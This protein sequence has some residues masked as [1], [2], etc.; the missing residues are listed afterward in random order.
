[1]KSFRNKLIRLA[2]GTPLRAAVTPY[3]ITSAATI[4][5]ARILP[6][7][8]LGN[9]G[10]IVAFGVLII[11]AWYQGIGPSVISPLLL[12]LSFRFRG[13]GLRDLF[14]F[15][16]KDCLDIF[17]ITLVITSVGVAGVL[18]RRAQAIADLR[19]EQ[20]KEQDRH[21]DEFLATLAHE[22]R[23]PLAPIRMGLEVMEMLNIECSDPAAFDDVKR[24]MRRQVDHMVRLIDDLLDVSR[25]KTGKLVI[26]PEPIEIAL[27]INDALE[28]ARAD[29][30]AACHDL[31]VDLPAEPILMN[32]DRVRMTQVIVNLLNNATKFT[33]AG[34]Q[35]HLRAHRLNDTLEIR[36]RDTGIG[37]SRELLP[38]VF[39]LFVQ[40]EDLLTRTHGGLGIGLSLVHR[41]M[42]LHGGQ[43]QAHSDGPGLGSEFVLTLPCPIQ[44]T[45]TVASTTRPGE[46]LS[47]RRILVVDDNQDAAKT[48]AMMLSAQG[49]HCDIAFDGIAA[50]NAAQTLRPDVFFLDL[51]MPAMSGFELANKLRST[52]DF[53]SSLLIAVT[54]WGRQQDRVNCLNA[55]FDEHMVKPIEVEKVQQLLNARLPIAASN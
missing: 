25:I 28:A 47:T 38:K 15:S 29:I 26:R 50:L 36:V 21:K 17:T 9:T 54:G 33:P 4:S 32:V 13:T 45:T 12:V 22:L 5:I 49:H 2:Y 31:K 40:S 46:E 42:E 1:M 7:T 11:C 8:A 34:G 10:G 37:I 18:R 55:G 41:L 52:D 35:I 3:L 43:V 19:T 48:L 24:M 16:A 20:L 30:H 6:M 53:K 27:V 51:G 14:V 39:N 23:N 44:P